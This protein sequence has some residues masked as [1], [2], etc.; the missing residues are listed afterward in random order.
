MTAP[1]APCHPPD[2]TALSTQWVLYEP[3][4]MGHWH[5]RLACAQQVHFGCGFES[6][7]GNRWDRP[8]GVLAWKPGAQG[9]VPGPGSS[10]D[11]LERTAGRGGEGRSQLGRADPGP[12]QHPE[13]PQAPAVRG[14]GMQ[15]LPPDGPAGPTP[16]AESHL[17]RARATTLHV[18]NLLGILTSPLQRSREM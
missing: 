8:P 14:S 13:S 1:A 3:L 11:W 5:C 10:S 18:F 9:A 17:R 6:A 7:L 15:L 4:W 12:G 2:Q 16:M